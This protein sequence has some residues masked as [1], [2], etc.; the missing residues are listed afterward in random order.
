MGNESQRAFEPLFQ[1]MSADSHVNKTFSFDK[2]FLEN[3]KYIENMFY[4]YFEWRSLKLHLS[5]KV[6]SILI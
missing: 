4:H 2:I 6:H 1:Y 3:S 5:F